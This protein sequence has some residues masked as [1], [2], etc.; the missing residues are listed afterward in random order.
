VPL[1]YTDDRRAVRDNHNDAVA[2]RLKPGVSLAQAQAEMDAIS[3]RLER[4]YPQANTG[5]GATVVPLQ[6]LIVGD[7]R[8]TLVM[9]LMAVALVLLDRPRERVSTCCSR[10][11]WDGARS[12]RSVRARGRT[13]PCLQQLL[14]EALVLATAGGAAGPLF[15]RASSQPG[16]DALPRRP[17]AWRGGDG[18]S[19]DVSRC[20]WPARRSWPPSLAG[21]L[22]ACARGRTGLNDAL[23]EGGRSEGAVGSAPDGC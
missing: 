17:G 2:A 7:I 5:W 4:E 23:K 22:P 15:A 14:T 13:R 19:M 16:S 6:E 11:V 21:A 12:W 18:R 20:S 10:V 1:A 3:Q 9:L 8:T